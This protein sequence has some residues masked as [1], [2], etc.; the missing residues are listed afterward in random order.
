MSSENNESK[1][2]FLDYINKHRNQIHSKIIDYIPNGLPERF[3]SM[4]KEYVNRQ[5]KY[6]RPSF[7]LLWA[8]LHGRD[9]STAYLPAAA[10]QCSEDWILMHDDFEDSNDLRRGKKAAHLLYGA[11][12]ALNAGD[13][14]HIINWKMVYSA[15]DQLKVSSNETIA[16]RF[17]E[18]FYDILL[19]TA[20]GQF[21]DMTLTHEKDITKFT[22]QD[23]LNS[24]HAKS[25]YYSVYGPMQLGAILAGKDEDY[26]KRIRTYG[27]PIG[28]AF[29]IKDD[30][31]DCLSTNE[32]LG[33]SVGNDIKEGVKTPILY[34]FVQ[35]ANEK[36][37]AK[38]KE[39]YS[40]ERND[41]TSEDVKFVL[42]MF[43]KYDSYKCA[44][45]LIDELGKKARDSFEEETKQISEMKLKEIA[46]NAIEKMVK[47]KK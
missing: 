6:A 40:K 26:V 4:V 21:Y 34:D 8:E 46:R 22:I 23:Y 41:K 1:E 29:Q 25:A 15:M 30:I 7:I 16:N 5:G 42:E 45:N 47:R 24:I 11:P 12:Q 9:P 33:K 39:I 27:E 2:L 38:V 43:K 36:D 3:D 37:L 14:L 17:F 32:V 10:M 18:K 13:Y 44:E 35:N 20:E 28:N 19:T 31:L